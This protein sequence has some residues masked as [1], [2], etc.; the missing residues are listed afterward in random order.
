MR[1]IKFRGQDVNGHWHIGL[2]SIS[3]ARTGQPEKGYYISN[4]AG[5]PW[6]YQV[7]PD[8]VGQYTGLKDKD[9]KEIYEGD[10]L[11]NQTFSDWIVKY[12][13]DGYDYGSG[14]DICGWLLWSEKYGE[15]V[16]LL[17]LATEDM[18]QVIGNATDNP[19]LLKESPDGKD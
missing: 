4:S 15:D 7:R 10:I 13:T 1:E 3:Q 19:E 18:V 12:S 14:C 16:S 11:S 17:S 2:L 6:A 8:T 5:S 9:G